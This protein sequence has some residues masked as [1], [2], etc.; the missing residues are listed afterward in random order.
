MSF[1]VCSL[2][3][4]INFIKTNFPSLDI[5]SRIF[6]QRFNA[7]IM[8]IALQTSFFRHR[9]WVVGRLRPYQFFIGSAVKF[10]FAKEALIYKLTL[11]VLQ[12]LLA[13]LAKRIQLRITNLV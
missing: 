4:P 10:Y 11:G 5:A 9:G 7:L 1:V 6:K 12:I 3:F 2:Y 8:R 13:H